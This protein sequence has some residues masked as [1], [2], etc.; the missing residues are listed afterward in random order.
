M[1]H[2]VWVRGLKP[3]ENVAPARGDVSHPVWV[4]GLKPNAHNLT[5]PNTKVAPRVG[6][7]IE[8][9]NRLPSFSAIYFVAPRVG[10]WIETSHRYRCR[11]RSVSHPVWVR[12]LK[13]LPLLYPNGERSDVAPRVGAWI[14]TDAS[15]PGLS[16]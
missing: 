7:W 2:P 8:T 3:T 6:A 14:E 13:P 12:G 10:A 5:S 4:R 15:I 9:S 1:S 16:R 11:Y